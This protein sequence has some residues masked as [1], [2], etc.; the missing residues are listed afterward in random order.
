MG[1]ERQP[2]PPP[3]P[4]RTRQA[5]YAR[6]LQFIFLSFPES[7]VSTR[8]TG[9]RLSS[10]SLPGSRSGSLRLRVHRAPAQASWVLRVL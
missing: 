8:V 1:P 6:T 9:A 3:A 4:A 5:R 10:V 7:C 2:A